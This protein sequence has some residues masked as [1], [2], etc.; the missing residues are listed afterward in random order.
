MGTIG[1]PPAGSRGQRGSTLAK[2]AAGGALERGRTHRA[3]PPG[4]GRAP[5]APDAAPSDLPVVVAAGEDGGV[6]GSA[7]AF[8]Q[9][10]PSREATRK[11]PERVIGL[12]FYHM[13]F[14]VPAASHKSSAGGRG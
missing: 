6:G 12:R 14:W 2:G 13:N 5:D 1:E 4:E 3:S 8:S 11:R 9:L 7:G 10:A